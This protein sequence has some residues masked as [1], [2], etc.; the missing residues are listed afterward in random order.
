MCHLFSGMGGSLAK[1]GSSAKFGVAVFKASILDYVGDPLAKV[2]LS[3]KF[4]VAVFQTS[5]PDSW[6]V[7]LPKYVHLPCF[8]Y[9]YARQISPVRAEISYFHLGGVWGISG[10]VE[11]GYI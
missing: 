7:H 4:G 11:E 6:G 5:M 3:A 8:V 10:G 2:G 1:E 9:W